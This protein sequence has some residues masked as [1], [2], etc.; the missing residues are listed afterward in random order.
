MQQMAVTQQMVLRTS[1]LQN[2]TPLAGSTPQEITLQGAITR[3]T[4]ITLIT[5]RAV[6]TQKVTAAQLTIAAGSMV[7]LQI[8]TP[9][10]HLPI[11][12]LNHVAACHSSH[13]LVS[14]Y[15]QVCSCIPEWIAFVCFPM[16][17]GQ[18]SHGSGC[19]S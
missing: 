13:F 19:L 16:H 2:T 8:M 18:V 7:Q 6:R 10:R 4:A 14:A 17:L 1:T 5:P 9:T 3:R 12:V 15:R 11:Y